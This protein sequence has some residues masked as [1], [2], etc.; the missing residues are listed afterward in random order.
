M[1]AFSNKV[2]EHFKVERSLIKY[3]VSLLVNSTTLFDSF[4]TLKSF[5][6]ILL[7]KYSNDCIDAK[8]YLEDKASSEIETLKELEGNNNVMPLDTIQTQ[9]AD[10]QEK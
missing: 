5:F 6:K 3:V 7:S 10:C 9:E 1:K 4:D 8:N 2:N